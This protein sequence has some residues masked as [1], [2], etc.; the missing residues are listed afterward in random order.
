[1]NDLNSLAMKYGTDKG[2]IY[3]RQLGHDYCRKYYQ[4]LFEPIQNHP[5]KLLEL[6]VAK[7]AS[8]RMW[9]DFFPYGKIYG[10]D[11]GKTWGLNRLP[12]NEPRIECFVLEIEDVLQ[13]VNNGPFDIIIDDCS[14][15]GE[16]QIKSFHELL[17]H[18][19]DGGLYIIEDIINDE[20]FANDAFMKGIYPLLNSLIYGNCTVV[21]GVELH[22]HFFVARK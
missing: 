15:H 4:R 12:K 20:Q 10:V 21:S 11:N 19:V 17:P 8:L 7:G 2:A 22:P 9:R 1:M 5:I 18:L 16:Q 6:G 3:R 13:I 14:H